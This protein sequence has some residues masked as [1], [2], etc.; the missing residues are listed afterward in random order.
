MARSVI[1]GCLIEVLVLHSPGFR[2]LRTHFVLA[3]RHLLSM[4]RSLH[5]GWGPKLGHRK[6]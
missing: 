5:V 4:E 6:L 3:A 1:A 2:L